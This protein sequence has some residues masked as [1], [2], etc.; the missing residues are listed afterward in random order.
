MSF[1]PR[2]RSIGAAAKSQ[3]CDIEAII[4]VPAWG[5]SSEDAFNA[6]NKAY[7]LKLYFFSLPPHSNTQV[8]TNHKNT[9]QGFKHFHG[10]SFSDPFVQSVKSSLVYELSQMPT[11]TTGIKVSDREPFRSGT[12]RCNGNHVTVTLL[13]VRHPLLTGARSGML[14]QPK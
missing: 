14:K 12:R 9:V 6:M 5:F 11:G 10:R 8:V 3:V 4:N 7:E 2:N 13:L 1:G